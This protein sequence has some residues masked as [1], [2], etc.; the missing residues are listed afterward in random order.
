MGVLV[1]GSPAL[2]CMQ[3]P[4]STPYLPMR[5][6]NEPRQAILRDRNRTCVVQW[7]LFNE[8][9]RPV[10]KQMMRPMAMLARDLDPT[11]LIL[12][13]SGGWAYGANMYLPSEALATEDGIFVEG[14]LVGFTD[15]LIPYADGQNDRDERH[16]QRDQQQFLTID[17]PTQYRTRRDCDCTDNPHTPV[18]LNFC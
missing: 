1:V 8:L 14:M 4:F 17:V 5:V 15:D 10:L 7:E 9:H 12:D 16:R 6:E 2:E 18:D 11:R 3:L 13:E